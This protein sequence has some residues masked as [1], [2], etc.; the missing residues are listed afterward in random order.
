MRFIVLT[1][2]ARRVFHPLLAWVALLMLSVPL[3]AAVVRQVLIC[4]GKFQF[5]TESEISM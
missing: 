1:T 5:P 2:Y 3:A 4:A